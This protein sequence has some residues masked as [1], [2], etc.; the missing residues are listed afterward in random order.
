VR[1][2][3]K[4][5]MGHGLLTMLAAIVALTMLAVLRVNQ[6]ELA[7]IR[8]SYEQTLFV[9]QVLAAANDYSEQIAEL[10]VLGDDPQEI[11]EARDVLFEAIT[12]AELAIEEE[13]ASLDP[14][15]DEE[16]IA[17][18]ADELA[19]LVELRAIIDGLETARTQ[20]T[21]AL[22]DGRSTDAAELYARD[23]ENSLDAAL[24]DVLQA[25]LLRERREVTD[26]LT[27][28]D[29]VS[30]RLRRISYVLV[31]ATAVAATAL[32]AFFYVS[33]LRPVAALSRG[34]EAVAAGDL[35]HRVDLRSDDA[36][37]NLAQRFNAMTAEIAR[38]RNDLLAAKEHL[39][40]E[41]A[42][43]TADLKEAADRQSELAESRARVLAD[44]SH[45]LRTP[46]TIIRGKAE[47][48]LGTP[49]ADGEMMKK[50]LFRILSK[51]EQM[52]RLVDDMLFVARTEAGAIPIK[53]EEIDLQD[54]VADVLL[55]SRDLS[56]RKGISILPRQPVTP[57][58]VLGDA[59]RL[60]QAMLI[61]L[62]N[63][64]RLAPEGSSVSLHLF[65][66]EGRAVVEI[67]DQGPGFVAEEAE[68][69]FGRFWSG[70][71][72]KAGSGRGSGLG[73]SI[74]RWIM[75]RHDGRIA[76]S[77]HDGG[78]AT[79]QLE[80]PLAPGAVA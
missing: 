48:T 24:D 44:L 76:L 59:D 50:A 13:I 25:S 23:V 20:I 39:E 4:V 40:T 55:D 66:A 15:A 38:Q 79:V 77:N 16:E 35:A 27:E 65:A 19:R 3:T 67:S 71:D 69:A 72:G 57:V 14:E 12:A 61:P 21:E 9:S 2:G 63:A 52:S 49:G 54:V 1:F 41:V 60:R 11:I 53:R 74:A 58:P 56:R 68:R 51:A 6:S 46:L 10:F 26:A 17:G 42:A 62:D 75:E 22:G 32:A 36:L 33:V 64:V 28:M 47:V 80:M 29:S 34:A 43:R 70:T 73:L 78:G 45:E 8:N 37:G 7:E 30:A 5:A 31:A 18:E